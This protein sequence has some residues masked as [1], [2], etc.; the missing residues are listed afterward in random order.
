MQNSHSEASSGS[1]NVL[2]QSG[3]APN[4]PIPMQSKSNR[5][6]P[7]ENQLPIRELHGVLPILLFTILFTI[8]FI[9]RLSTV[10]RELPR[11]LCQRLQYRLALWIRFQ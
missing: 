3:Q 8:V 11:T 6:R 9:D 2:L 5:Q 7:K 10:F 4:T 1:L